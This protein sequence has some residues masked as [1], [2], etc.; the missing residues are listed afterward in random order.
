QVGENIL[1]AGSTAGRIVEAEMKFP[2]ARSFTGSAAAETAK[3]RTK[4]IA[5]AKAA[6]ARIEAARI[7]VGADRARVELGALFLVAQN[8]IGA[9]NFL[10][11]LLC[12]R[13]ARMLVG[14]MF[15]GQRPERF[16]DVGLARRLG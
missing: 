3:A 12:R 9:G 6:L 5:L 8:V 4:W 16:L 14:M 7:A 2:R 1:E 13:V 11:T 10:E 15:L